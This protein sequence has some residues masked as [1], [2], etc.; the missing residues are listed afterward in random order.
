MMKAGGVWRVAL[1]GRA[2]PVP[3][4]HAHNLPV[5][6]LELF[7]AGAARGV[8]CPATMYAPCR[9]GHWAM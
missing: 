8:Q 1:P 3:V 6:V 2:A 9:K 5:R 7:R 4:A